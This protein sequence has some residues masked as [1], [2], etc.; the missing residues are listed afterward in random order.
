MPIFTGTI[1]TWSP[2]KTNTTSTCLGASLDFLSAFAV[3]VVDNELVATS[4]LVEAEF[5]PVAVVLVF[6]GLSFPVFLSLGSRAVTLAM[7][8]DRT[9]VR[10][11]VS[12]SAVTDI[13]G[14][15]ASFS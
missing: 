6:A 10:E 12:I 1:F 2:C 8:T 14:R 3:F 5:V 15:K 13:P 7:G 4:E 11:R 9:F